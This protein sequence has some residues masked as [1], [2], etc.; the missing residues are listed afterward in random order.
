MDLTGEFSAFLQDECFVVSITCKQASKSQ[1]TLLR[2]LTSSCK[3]IG[4]FMSEDHTS[5]WQLR[6]VALHDTL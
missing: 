5:I 4:S 1:A 2:R 6:T 3:T